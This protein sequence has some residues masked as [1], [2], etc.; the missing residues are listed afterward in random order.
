MKKLQN[1][2]NYDAKAAW[3]GP[4][5]SYDLIKELVIAITVVAVLSIGLS[6]LFSSPDERAITL[7]MWVSHEPND[8]ALTTVGELAGST[9]SAGYGPPYNLNGNAQ[10]IG[11]ISLN[12]SIKKI[13]PKNKIYF[14]MI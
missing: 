3:S 11:F 9:T 5:R 7:K 1:Y 6:A 10:K 12:E 4:K 13:S 2:K 8:F 14:E